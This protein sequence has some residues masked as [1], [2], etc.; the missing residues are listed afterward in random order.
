MKNNDEGIDKAKSDSEK[1]IMQT[2]FLMEYMLK[3]SSPNHKISAEELIMALY[4][5]DFESNKILT[6]YDPNIE[7][8]KTYQSRVTRFIDDFKSMDE[9]CFMGFMLYDANDGEPFKCSQRRYYAEGYLTEE[10]VAVLRDAIYV[11]PYAEPV[12]TKSIVDALNHLT[13]NYN[14][15]EYDPKLVSANK[16]PGTYYKNLLEIYKAFSAIEYDEDNERDVITAEE[17]DMLQSDYIRSF[18]KQISRISFEYYEYA[19][20][21]QTRKIVMSPK[22]MKNGSTLRTVNPLKLLWSNGYYYLVTY[23]KGK[24]G[25]YKYLNYR[26]DRMKNVKCTSEPVEM[27]EN[28]RYLSDGEFSAAKYKGKNPVMYSTEEGRTDITIRCKKSVLNNVLDTFGFDI[29]IKPEPDTDE[30][31]VELSATAPE[32]AIMWALEYWHSAEIISP[33]EVREKM[34]AAAKNLSEKYK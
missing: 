29:K 23:F 8:K 6:V 13:N 9:P 11:Y 25:E 27:L 1:K 19:F 21:E 2:F 17:S 22:V 14:Q 7:K 18:K 12:A 26:V 32:G 24:D 10:Q 4:N 30:L 3:H 33:A 16:Y 28:S 31:L 5:Y 34:K 20:D 15:M